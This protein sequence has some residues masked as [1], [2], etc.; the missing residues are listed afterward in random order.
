[1]QHA[2]FNLQMSLKKAYRIF[3]LDP[4]ITEQHVA[5]LYLL[6]WIKIMMALLLQIL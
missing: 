4:I 3:G 2:H 1:M 6:D 5:I